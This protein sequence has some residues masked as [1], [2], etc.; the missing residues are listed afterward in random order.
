MV[1]KSGSDCK[2]IVKNAQ[3][4][5]R[6]VNPKQEYMD[7][8]QNEIGN[9][10]GSYPFLRPV[11]HTFLIPAD[12]GST[13]YSIPLTEIPIRC[14]MVMIPN[15]VLLGKM[16]KNPTNFL[17]HGL[18]NCTFQINGRSYPHSN[19]YQIKAS[20]TSYDGTYQ[21]VYHQLLQTIGI[22]NL[23]SGFQVTRTEYPGGYFVL[24]FSFA[25]NKS[26]SYF[27]P[28][29]QGAMQISLVFEKPIPKPIT[30]LLLFQYSSIIKISS[31][32]AIKLSYSG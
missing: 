17:A 7:K 3:F 11:T 1:K 10:F 25:P 26:D 6:T 22:A 13:V 19:G 5:V 9:G 14:F 24:P 18:T 12:A 27:T 32:G 2:I 20:S 8:L 23:D 30:V 4:I 15:D 31:K 16:D 29:K 21:E 28:I